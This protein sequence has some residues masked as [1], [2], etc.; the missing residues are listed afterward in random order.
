[1]LDLLQN[2]FSI[3][4][5]ILPYVFLLCVI[6]VPRLRKPLLL[7][8]VF[9]LLGLTLYWTYENEKAMG[10]TYEGFRW[11]DS[12]YVDIIGLCIGV[13]IV[14]GFIGKCLFPTIYIKIDKED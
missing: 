13:I 6:F 9:L 7:S 2:I 8:Y 10:I 4:L 11:L 12:T 5:A 3:F 14:V 1:M